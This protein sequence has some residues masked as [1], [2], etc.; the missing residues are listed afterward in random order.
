MIKRLLE[1]FFR[2]KLLVLMPPILLPLIVTPI[3]IASTPKVY[4]TAVG[5]WVDPPA[6]LNYKDGFNPWTT[7]ATQQAARLGELLRTRAF[8]VDVAQRTPTLAPLVGNPA[9]EATLSD[10]IGKSVSLG[11]AATGAALGS[12][13][14]DHLLV[15]HVQAPTAKLSYEMCKALIDAYQE[16]SAAD[17]ADQSDSA[18]QFFQSRTDEAQQQLTKATQDVRRYVA[19]R[20]SDPTTADTAAAS[21]PASLLDPKLA[22]LQAA[23]QQAQS[24]YNLA[25]NALTQAQRDSVAAQQGQQYGFQV[26]DEPQMPTAP[27]SQMKKIIVYPIAGAMAGLVLATVILV[28]LVASDRS[29]RYESDLTPGLRVVGSVPTLKMK[30]VPK[31]LRSVATRRAIGS[32]AGT[33]LPAPGG[34]K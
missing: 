8:L 34:A 21:L 33:A 29:I 22:G 12:T 10:V 5:V 23:M 1:A 13:T 4:D 16:K 26:L 7:P 32:I 31:R 6:Y 9:S 28:L 19:S 15:I 25:Q 24:D 17:Q 20:Q 2:H 3:A 27:V 30:R 14:G 11:G 18:I